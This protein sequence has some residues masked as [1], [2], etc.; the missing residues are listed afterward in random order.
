M[1]VLLPTIFKVLKAMVSSRPSSSPWGAPVLFVKKKN[2]SFRM[3]IDYQELNKLT[4]RILRYPLPRI[5][6]LFDQLQGSRDFSKIDLRL[7]LSSVESTRRRYSQ[8]CFQD[9]SHKVIAYASRKLKIIEKNYT[10]HDLELG[11]VVFAPQNMETLFVRTKSVIYTD[12]KSLQHIFDQKEL[13]MR[14]RRWIELFSDYD[15]EIRYHPVFDCSKVK[16]EHQKPSGLLQQPEIPEWKWENITMDFIDTTDNIVQIKER[17]KDLRDRQKSYADNRRKPLEFSVGDKVLLKVS[18]W[19]GVVRLAREEFFRTQ[20]AVGLRSWLECM[21]SVFHISKCLAESQ[22]EFATCML[23][24]LSVVTG[25]HG[26]R[27]EG[28]LKQFKTMKVNEPK[29]KD[30]PVIREFPGMFPED[31][32]GLPKSREVE[33][34]IDL[35]P[36][37]MPAAKSP[38]RLEPT[39]MQELSNQLKELQDKGFIRPSSSPWEHRINDLFDQLQGLWYFSKIDLRSGYHQLRVHEEDIPKTAFRTMPYLDKFVIVFID[40]I[41]IYSKSKE[42]HEFGEVSRYLVIRHVILREDTQSFSLGNFDKCTNISKITRKQSKAGKHGHGNQKS[43]KEAKD[44]KAESKARKSQTLSQSGQIMGKTRGKWKLRALLVNSR[45]RLYK[46]REKSVIFKLLVAHS[47]A[48]GHVS[49]GESTRV[50]GF[51]TKASHRSNTK[52]TS[53]IASLAIHVIPRNDPTAYNSPP[54]IGK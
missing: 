29:L 26:E 3:C 10:T 40:D 31:L 15:C 21:E 18:P 36:G 6:D 43:T 35:I 46:G 7:G 34:R 14:Q 9:E 53:R 54:M 28:N 32:S 19:K 51:C 23:Q 33:F 44:S 25:V 50:C 27:P 38:Y 2:D 48:L 16:A 22:V 13:N 47:Q 11:A 17:L 39:E 8:N 30:I 42:E 12:H 41:L 1:Q 52:V 24:D 49:Y 37:A 5:D 4:I 45:A 20:G